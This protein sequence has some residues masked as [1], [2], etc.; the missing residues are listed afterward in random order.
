M[1]EGEDSTGNWT[2]YGRT[3]KKQV[4][5][6]GWGGRGGGGFE[7]FISRENMYTSRNSTIL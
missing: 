1:L 3:Q 7:V 4:K 2:K 5:L 6:K